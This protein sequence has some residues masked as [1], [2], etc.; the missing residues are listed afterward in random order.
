VNQE[1]SETDVCVST[2]PHQQY[3]TI[4]EFNVDSKAECD[5]HLVHETKTNKRQSALSSVQVKIREGRYEPRVH[6][7]TALPSAEART[8][9]PWH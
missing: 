3:D 6:R 2:M 4:K 1:D 8:A 5:Q 7:D 9:S